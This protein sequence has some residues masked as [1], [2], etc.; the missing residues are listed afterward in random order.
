MV[1]LL[2]PLTALLLC[3]GCSA[4]AHPASGRCSSSLDATSAGCA[5][6]DPSAQSLHLSLA[7][8]KAH[9][10]HLF[11]KLEVTNRVQVAIAMH[12]A[13]LL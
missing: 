4:S 1:W 13:G 7:T 9:V 8:V 6:S 10:S 5:E 3:G 12:E 11:T 2:L